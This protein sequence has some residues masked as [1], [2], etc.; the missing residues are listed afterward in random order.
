MTRTED[1][2][3]CYHCYHCGQ[4]VSV[5]DA[6]GRAISRLKEQCI[7]LVPGCPECEKKIKQGI[8]NVT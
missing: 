7:Q 1:L 2:M 6:V 3:T 4:P 5:F 8:M